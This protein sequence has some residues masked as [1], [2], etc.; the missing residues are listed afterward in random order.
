MVDL[1]DSRS[2]SY[3]RYGYVV[4]FEN[5]KMTYRLRTSC[6]LRLKT[7]TDWFWGRNAIHDDREHSA[8]HFSDRLCASDKYIYGRLWRVQSIS[9]L[10]MR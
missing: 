9:D 4:D 5:S 1:E 8:G 3:V 10:D 6:S 2:R 7:V